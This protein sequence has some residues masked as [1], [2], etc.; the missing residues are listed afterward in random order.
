MFEE[1]KQIVAKETLLI[2]PDFNKISDIDKYLSEYQLNALIGQE[3]K[4]IVFYTR[5]LT[6]PKTRYTVTE[7]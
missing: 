4:P 7:K 2:Y 1:I 5:K 6:D 3:G